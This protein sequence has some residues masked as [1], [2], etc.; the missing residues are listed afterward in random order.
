MLLDMQQEA[1]QAKGEATFANR[2][3]KDIG[4]RMAQTDYFVRQSRRMQ[5]GGT[6][7]LLLE[8][9]TDLSWLD[10]MPLPVLTST[11]TQVDL[12][13]LS[14][15]QGGRAAVMSGSRASFHRS[16]GSPPHADH[17]DEGAPRKKVHGFRG[18]RGSSDGD[19][20]V[21]R[22]SMAGS[23]SRVPSRA[24]SQKEFSRRG[25]QISSP[26]QSMNLAG[27]S[28]AF[29]GRM[30][31]AASGAISEI[32]EEPDNF[33]LE[34]PSIASPDE[35]G[36]EVPGK[37]QHV[38]V[39]EMAH[40]IARMSSVL[41]QMQMPAAQVN[42]ERCTHSQPAASANAERP[43]TATSALEIPR[44]LRRGPGRIDAHMHAP[45]DHDTRPRTT[46]CMGR[47]SAQHGAASSSSQHHGYHSLTFAGQEDME[48]PSTGSSSRA[49]FD[50][51]STTWKPEASAGGIGTDCNAGSDVAQAQTARRTGS[52]QS[53]RPKSRHE[54]D[55]Y[56][57]P[58]D[59]ETVSPAKVDILH[60]DDVSRP[61]TLPGTSDNL[62]P[63]TAGQWHAE[64]RRQAQS[65]MT[66]DGG[67]KWHAVSC[68]HSSDATFQTHGR[69]QGS[70]Q[71]PEVLSPAARGGFHP[72]PARKDPSRPSS[73]IGKQQEDSAVNPSSSMKVSSF[74]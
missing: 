12:K 38:N 21:I 1:K 41:Q 54:P 46:G 69:A 20:A 72:Q 26:S 62:R 68:K 3:M 24:P 16:P 45:R 18:A 70:Q 60:M 27:A 19:G 44:L 49:S 32:V 23:A 63:R 42:P 67:A 39:R 6:Q 30:S 57:A 5:H 25:S 66:P 34:D 50:G 17:S 51:Q 47:Q 13:D 4:R 11:A 36:D 73:R 14:N 10:E 48:N 15:V 8:P 28:A 52:P 55:M 9:D 71:V 64:G 56:I 65:P 31:R 59:D 2:M 40:K 43:R 29:R 74:R 35:V 58:V 37:Q 22:S 33:A 53:R 7:S 61:A